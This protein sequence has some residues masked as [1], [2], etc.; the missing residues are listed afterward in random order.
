[1]PTPKMA[2]WPQRSRMRFVFHVASRSSGPGEE[3]RGVKHGLGR[4]DGV[5]AAV[6]GGRK[7]T[8]PTIPSAQLPP[9]SRLLI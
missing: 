6:G 5:K 2:P 4:V 3:V 9:P 8:S 7:A 1:M